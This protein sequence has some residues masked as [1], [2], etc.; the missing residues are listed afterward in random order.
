MYS[1][2]ALSVAKFTVAPV[3]PGTLFFRT[4]S[5]VMA[6][7]AQDIPVMGSVILSLDINPLLN[8]QPDN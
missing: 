8:Q 5:M 2:E 6:Q 3:T 4:L 1:T 7:F